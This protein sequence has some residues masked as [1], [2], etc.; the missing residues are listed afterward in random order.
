MMIIIVSGGADTSQVRHH[1]I[2]RRRKTNKQINLQI[3]LS[4]PSPNNKNKERLGGWGS[5]IRKQS[6][7]SKIRR[8]RNLD[9]SVSRNTTCGL[10]AENVLPPSDLSF[11]PPLSQ[12]TRDAK[13]SCWVERVQ[14]VHT[15][16]TKGYL[17]EVGQEVRWEGISSL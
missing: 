11:F 3:T 17:G 16:K 4:P 6:K 8:K 1:F 13:R 9:L 12:R 5:T 2:R 7:N 10:D 15:G 14:F